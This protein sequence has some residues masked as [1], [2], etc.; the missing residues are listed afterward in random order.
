MVKMGDVWDRTVDFLGDNVGALLPIVVLAIF[1]P[2][3]I[4]GSLEGLRASAGPGLSLGLAILSLAFGIVA[5]WAQLAIT[6]LAIDPAIGRG[7]GR[8]ATARLLPAIGVFIL[9][10]LL[11]ALAAVPLVAVLVTSHI[12]FAAMSG[13]Q[14]AAPA[15]SPGMGL[16]LFLLILVTLAAMLWLA[17]RLMPLTAVILAERRGAGAIGRA[18]ALT[19]GLTWRLIGVMILYAVVALVAVMAAQTVF[20][21]ILRLVA[22]GEGDVTVASVITAVVVAA[23]QA[24]FTTL[25][26]AFAAKLY[27]AVRQTGAADRAP[28]H[29]APL[30]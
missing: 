25:A 17:A 14:M 23:V 8:A 16:T 19:R 24:G 30:A 15:L 18:F 29:D 13:G 20:G 6:A 4:S 10:G 9:V 1:V 28:P 21:S 11:F 3:S 26:A 7:A 12:D 2:T 27:V 5:I 22:G